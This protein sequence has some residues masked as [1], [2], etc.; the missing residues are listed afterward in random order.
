VLDPFVDAEEVY[1]VA[2][3]EDVEGLEEKAVKGTTTGKE[4]KYEGGLL[5]LVAADCV[6]V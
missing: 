1:E 4:L 5:K 2:C 6:F 3:P